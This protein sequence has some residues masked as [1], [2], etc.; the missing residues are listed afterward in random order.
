M[1]ESEDTFESN[2]KIVMSKYEGHFKDN[3]SGLPTENLDLFLSRFE[4]NAKLRDF[5]P[6]IKLKTR[7]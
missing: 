4:L 5:A 3:F 6:S 7:R 2:T 1:E